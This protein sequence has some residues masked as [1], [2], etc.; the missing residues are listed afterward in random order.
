VL[1]LSL[2]CGA[3]QE[4][5]DESLVEKVC[6]HAQQ[7]AQ[8]NRMGVLTMETCRTE[9]RKHAAKLHGGFYG[10]ANCLLNMES[11]EEAKISCRESDYMNPQ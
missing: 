6:L 7:V 2:T 1:F 3:K 10:W 5:T 9:L 8:K 4:G 11:L